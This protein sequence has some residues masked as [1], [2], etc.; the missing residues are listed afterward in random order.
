M[1]SAISV[2]TENP[3]I[4]LVAAS[5]LYR[6]PPWGKLDQP[7]FFNAV[8]ELRTSLEPRQLLD[9]CLETERALKRERRERWGPRIIDLDII[10]FGQRRIDQPDLHIPHPRL[11]ER[12]FVL[13]PL[14]EIAP[15]LEIGGL[16][17]G[18]LAETVDASGIELQVKGDSW[19]SD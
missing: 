17:I 11:G 18:N 6:T 14:A 3:A 8:I 2:L 7:D 19:L 1:A 10:A 9:A 5:S 15:R 16:L 13:V 4:E 12:A